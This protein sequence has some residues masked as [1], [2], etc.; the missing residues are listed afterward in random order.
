MEHNTTHTPQHRR[1]LR[2]K[3]THTYTHTLS[4][5]LGFVEQVNAVVVDNKQMCL[6]VESVCMN[7]MLLVP[8]TVPG[9]GS[10]VGNVY[11]NRALT[12]LS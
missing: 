3:H 9:C 2:S 11:S 7:A 1:I 6:R 8:T 5:W 4:L 12:S 10:K